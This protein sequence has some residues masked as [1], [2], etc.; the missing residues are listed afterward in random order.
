MRVIWN[1]KHVLHV[2]PLEVEEG[3]VTQ[4]FEVPGRFDAIHHALGSRGGFTFEEPKPIP[5]ESLFALHDPDYVA[6][7]REARDGFAMPSVFPYGPDPK[8]R[9]AKMR[10]GLY[11]FDTYTPITSGTFEAALN[12]A[13]AALHGAELLAA[14]TERSLYVLTRPPGHHAERSRCG[15]YSYFNNAALAAQMLTMMGPVAVLDLD[16]HHG[17]GTQH[18]FFDRADVLT[19][20]L[21]G[22]PTH[23]FPYFSGFA[24]ET[25]T[26]PGLGFNLNLPL[27][28]GSTQREYEPALAV[29]LGRIAKFHPAFLVVPFGADAH[30]L[31]P[32]GGMKITTEEFAEWGRLVKQ[33]D[34]PTLVVQEGGYNLDVLGPSVAAFLDGLR[35]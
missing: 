23:L 28:A 1:P 25:G 35:N 31:D 10:K 8:P 13:A 21:H 6:Y 2:P 14:G 4:P 24:D 33:L 29:A 9:T 15:G 20:S 19:V 26:G 3:T 17:N 34:L 18:L 22:D 12:G 7:I 27:P 11:C 5:V 16:V 32:I 30:E